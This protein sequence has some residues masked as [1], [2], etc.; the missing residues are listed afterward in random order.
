MPTIIFLRNNF[1]KLYSYDI[2]YCFKSACKENPSV[3][4]MEAVCSPEKLVSTYK[5]T[6]C[7]NPEDQHRHLH[8]RENFRAYYCVHTISLLDPFLSQMNPFHTLLSRL[9]YF[10]VPSMPRSSKLSVPFRFYKYSPICITI[11][12]THA[13]YHA[14]SLQFYLAKR[15]N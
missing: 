8:C 6:L 15:A 14:I 13:T 10:A 1:K 3:L 9:F 11:Y 2:S 5:S 4:R 7:Y 12:P